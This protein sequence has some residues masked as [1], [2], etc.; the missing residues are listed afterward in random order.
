MICCAWEWQSGVC[1]C[2]FIMVVLEGETG[3]LAGVKLSCFPCQG[4]WLT[5]MG[6][7]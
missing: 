5:L 3:Q 6:N 4:A 1:V 2:V 7:H